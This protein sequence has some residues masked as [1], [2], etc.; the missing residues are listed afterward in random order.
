VRILAIA[1]NTFRE[2]VRDKVFSLVWAFGVLLLLST[3]IMSPLT[4][5]AQNK[6]V[7]DFGLASM[8][9]FSLLVVLLVGSGMVH[10]E[11]D[12]RTIITLLAKPITRLEFLVGKS[13]G[14]LATITVMIAAMTALFLLAIALTRTEFR[15]AYL[16]SIALSLVEMIVVVS[17]AMFFSSFTG[18]M[19]TSLFTLAVFVAGH[20]LRDLQAFAIAMENTPIRIG[21]TVVRYILPDLELF[22]IRNAAVHGLPVAATHVLWSLLYGL[23]YAAALMGLAAII[24]RRR[25]FK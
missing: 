7:A 15:A 20:T 14:L 23:S 19:L 9:A 17:V 16:V 5:G 25:E 8:V 4:I 21:S 3:I 10:K 12:K 2:A 24:F 11:I 6:I 22:N 18:S 1:H 13:L